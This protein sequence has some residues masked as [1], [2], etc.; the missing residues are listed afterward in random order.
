VISFPAPTRPPYPPMS[1]RP[2]LRWLE[3]GLIVLGLALLALWLKNESDSRA[4][5]VAESKRLEAA[6]HESGLMGPPLPDTGSRAKRPLGLEKGVLGR[7]EIPRLGISAMVAEGTDTR[8]L[9]RAV[10]HITTT[11]LPGRPGNV[12]LAGHR[13][14]FLRGLGDARENDLIRFV[15]LRGTYIYRVEWGAVVEPGRVDVLDSTATPTMTLVTCY[16]F[17]AVGPAPQR[18]VVRARQVAPAVPASTAVR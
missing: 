10:G 5:Q 18:F 2:A 15:T 1:T 14:T 7:L 17:Q 8:L 3:R 11:A 9:K 4:F 16:P 12:G 6:L 13:D